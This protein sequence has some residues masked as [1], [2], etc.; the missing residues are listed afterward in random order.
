M[1]SCLHIDTVGRTT[2]EDAALMICSV[3]AE[4]VVTNTG[5]VEVAETVVTVAGDWV[6]VV[7]AGEQ[8]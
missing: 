1:F 6:V 8:P 7:A 2:N 4:N 3:G 5:A